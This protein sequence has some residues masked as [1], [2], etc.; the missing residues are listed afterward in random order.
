MI[1]LLG[2]SVVA[3]CFIFYWACTTPQ[4][5]LDMA[6]FR[7]NNT[8]SDVAAGICIWVFV[9]GFINLMFCAALHI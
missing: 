1:E 4:I 5:Y 9:A 8:P 3:T 2:F 7:L 6:L